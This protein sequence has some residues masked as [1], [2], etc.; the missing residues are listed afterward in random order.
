MDSGA[1]F[2]FFFALCLKTLPSVPKIFLKCLLFPFKVIL[3]YKNHS[4]KE[5]FGVLC[6]GT[7]RKAFIWHSPGE[8][9]HH[10]LSK[11]ICLTSGRKVGLSY[12]FC[13]MW[14]PSRIQYVPNTYTYPISVVL[15][16]GRIQLLI[17]GKFKPVLM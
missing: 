15:R 6:Y 4:F 12:M 10:G 9:R 5:F 1:Q 2:S 14:L 11:N 13:T 16:A 3:S 17:S 7:C 8:S